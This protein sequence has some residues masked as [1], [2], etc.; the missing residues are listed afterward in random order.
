MA[1]AAFVNCAQPLVIAC[2]FQ[3]RFEAASNA[4]GRQIAGSGG[5]MGLDG[6]DRPAVMG[7]RQPTSAPISTMKL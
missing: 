7:S 1:D 5:A 2:W 6:R 3:G 4:S